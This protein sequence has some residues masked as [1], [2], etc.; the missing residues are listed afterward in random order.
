MVMVEMTAE[1][2]G[3]ELTVDG[4]VILSPEPEA[5]I[6]DAYPIYPKSV[7]FDRPGL[8]CPCQEWGQEAITYLDKDGTMA[9]I[10]GRGL[11]PR[12]Q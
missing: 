2:E 4:L 5:G 6:W 8:L 11:E 1:G 12:D 9:K 10:F 3:R 7:N